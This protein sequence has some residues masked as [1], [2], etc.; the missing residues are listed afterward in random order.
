MNS[1]PNIGFLIPSR[2][3]CIMVKIGLK[4]TK[5]VFYVKDVVEETGRTVFTGIF[6]H[7]IVSDPIKIFQIKEDFKKSKKLYVTIE[8]TKKATII[9]KEPIV[10]EV[11]S[12]LR[13]VNKTKDKIIDGTFV[14]F[15]NNKDEAIILFELLATTI[16]KAQQTA[17]NKKNIA[18]RRKTNTLM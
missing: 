3:F 8:K 5:K 13:T 7:D 10:D 6:I 11:T 4:G 9:V 15:E 18:A 1:N 16:Q 17:L 12:L 14:G 2:P